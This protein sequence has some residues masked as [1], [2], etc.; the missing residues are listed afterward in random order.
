[1]LLAGGSALAQPAA[2]PSAEPAAAPMPQATGATSRFPIRGFE[3]TGDV[4][5][6][7]AQISAVLDS[8]IGEGS[9]ITLQQATEE[10][11]NALKVAGFELHR[12]S[13]V[14]QDLGGMVK[15]EIVKFALG[16][17]IVEG[18]SRYS[19]ANVRASLP[20]LLEGR[21]PNFRTLAVQ[22]A[23]ANENP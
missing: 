21:A 17:I 12:V 5:L 9:L 22:T 18:N 11:E 6:S 23:I 4:P 15:L 10:L 16:K 7:A 2:A 1:M 3:V 14:P 8:F 13:L 19:E 20:E